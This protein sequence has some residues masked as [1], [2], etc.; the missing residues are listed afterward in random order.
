MGDVH[1]PFVFVCQ[2]VIARSFSAPVSCYRKA[3][4]LTAYRFQKQGLSTPTLANAEGYYV[5]L[6]VENS[7]I[8]HGIPVHLVSDSD[9]VPHVMYHHS[10]V[11][12]HLLIIPKWNLP[13][14]IPAKP[15]CEAYMFPP[16]GIL[17]HL[18]SGNFILCEAMVQFDDLP[19][20]RVMFK[21]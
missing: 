6:C 15:S 18:P 3:Y 9:Y 21:L 7:T 2:R 13:H 17:S 4:L 1:V 11:V 10:P 5:I 12:Q 20:K 14:Q 8:S 16:F 19:L